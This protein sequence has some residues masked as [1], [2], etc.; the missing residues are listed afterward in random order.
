MIYLFNIQ[1]IENFSIFTDFML[2]NIEINKTHMLSS[3]DTDSKLTNFFDAFLQKMSIKTTQKTTNNY[4]CESIAVSLFDS[5]NLNN[6]CDRLLNNSR[7]I[8]TPF[9]TI[10]FTIK[11]S[12]LRSDNFYLYENSELE[13]L[14]RKSKIKNLRF[15]PKLHNGFCISQNISYNFNFSSENNENVFLILSYYNTQIN[16]QNEIDIKKINFDEKIDYSINDINQNSI[17]VVNNNFESKIINSVNEHYYN[18]YT[19]YDYVYIICDYSD[20]SFIENTDDTNLNSVEKDE[21]EHFEMNDFTVNPILSFSIPPRYNEIVDKI[22]IL[23]NTDESTLICKN[24]NKDTFVFLENIVKFCLNYSG[25]KV[26]YCDYWIT[27]NQKL[28]FDN[29]FCKIYILYDEIENIRDFEILSCKKKVQ[30]FYKFFTKKNISSVIFAPPYSKYI[31]NSS[32]NKSCVISVFPNNFIT[33]N[34]SIIPGKD[35]DAQEEI[36]EKN[37]FDLLIDNV[38][39]KDEPFYL[40]KHK[41]FHLQTDLELMSQQILN[42]KDG[43]ILDLDQMWFNNVSGINN[44]DTD[45]VKK[46]YDACILT[47]FLNYDLINNEENIQK[48]SVFY[49]KIVPN[50]LCLQIISDN[51]INCFQ[52]NENNFLKKDFTFDFDN[53]DEIF[54]F[55]ILKLFEIFVAPYFDYC[56]KTDCQPNYKSF[57]ILSIDILRYNV[58]SNKINFFLEEDEFNAYLHLNET[59]N[60]QYDTLVGDKE[61]F[62]DTGNILL[63][64]NK[65]QVQLKTLSELDKFVI[66]YKIKI[67]R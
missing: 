48:Y 22:K 9:Q 50:Y 30:F 17:H 54:K 34:V 31:H 35:D 3:L 8:D 20:L 63:H 55:K 21:Q 14:S 13:K 11:S 53:S 16:C 28:D 57:D 46:N 40:T 5:K 67:Q 19:E 23:N 25:Y 52:D 10:F 24:T 65:K 58:Y 59:N 42:F 66:I 44:I 33:K 39:T 60:L 12:N 61:I 18:Q 2:K 38:I 56:F 27:L 29:T 6:Y 49:N 4:Q 47:P 26:N 62:N 7:N 37:N 1:D 32:K 45:F 36:E 43:E 15:T 41:I 64:S 51:I